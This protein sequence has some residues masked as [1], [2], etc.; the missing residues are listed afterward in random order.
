MVFLLK[1]FWQNEFS[2]QYLQCNEANRLKIFS[3]GGIQ[4]LQ[5]CCNVVTMF[6]K[7]IIYKAPTKSGF[8]FNTR[9]PPEGGFSELSQN[10]NTFKGS[11]RL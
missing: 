7:R 5:G 3:G 8:L 10:V 9:K 1:K 4:T 6:N 2:M 11:F